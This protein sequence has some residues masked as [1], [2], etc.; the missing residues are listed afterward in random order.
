MQLY[1]AH[2]AVA[3]A[4][5]LPDK[6]RAEST[7]Q[8]GIGAFLN[9]HGRWSNLPIVMCMAFMASPWA[10]GLRTMLEVSR[11]VMEA[12]NILSVADLLVSN[13]ASS[14]VS[15]ECKGSLSM[16]LRD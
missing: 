16:S 2:V 7:A 11:S 4:D 8:A 1:V 10:A 9:L 14:A 5:L 6:L 15:L 12:S 13:T 3:K